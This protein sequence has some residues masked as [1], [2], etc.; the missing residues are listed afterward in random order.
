MCPSIRAHC[1]GPWALAKATARLG[2]R[3]LVS[4]GLVTANIAQWSEASTPSQR[5]FESDQ[6][7]Q[8]TRRRVDTGLCSN[9]EGPPNPHH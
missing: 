4:E 1:Q 6:Q 9:S 8:V 7:H 5:P 2:I 3:A